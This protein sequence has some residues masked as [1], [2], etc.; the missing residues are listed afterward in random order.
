M[1]R[2]SK[3]INQN[4][5]LLIS[6]LSLFCFLATFCSRNQ[7][8]G[9]DL[10]VNT[11]ATTIHTEAF[12]QVAI[13]ISYLFDTTIFLAFTFLIVGLLIYKKQ[14][15]NALLLL[16]AMGIA[17]LFLQFFKTFV[18]SP[19]PLNGIILENSYS[20]PSGHLTSAIVFLVILTYF[21]WKSHKS[22]GLKIGLSALASALVL[23]VGFNRIYLNVHWLTDVIVAPFLALFILTASILV[24]KILTSIYRKRRYLTPDLNYTQFSKVSLS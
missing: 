4:V 24:V 13:I 16:S 15:S 21:M 10:S 3:S 22:S 5:M 6:I 18:V 11:W 20:F 23:L 8:T 9:L 19:R 14:V 12:T 2:T 17:V 1:I 7:F